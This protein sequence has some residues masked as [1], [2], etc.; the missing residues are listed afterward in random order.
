METLYVLLVDDEPR[1]LE[2]TARLLIRRGCCV[3]TA[4]SGMDALTFLSREP[5]HVVVLD[6]KMPGMDG[7]ETFRAI[8]KSHP[9][10]EVILLTGHGTVD[11]AVEGLKAG[12]FDYLVKP[13]DINRLWEKVSE[14]WQANRRHAEKIRL[15]TLEQSMQSPRD[16]LKQHGAPHVDV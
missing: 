3:A 12:A 13:V 14:A 2:N 6:V 10:V 15:A 11:S 16:I 7:H 4:T 9:L 5:V 8:K 1:Y